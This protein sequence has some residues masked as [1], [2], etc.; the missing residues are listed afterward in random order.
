MNATVKLTGYDKATEFLASEV[1][2]PDPLIPLA[3]TLAQVPASDPRIL[4]MYPLS[5]ESATALAAA[6][7]AVLDLEHMDYFL[8]AIAEPDARVTKTSA[9]TRSPS[10]PPTR[11]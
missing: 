6:A 7:N 9:A 4:A 11:G 8:E 1:T 3:R 10:G 5:T 2:L